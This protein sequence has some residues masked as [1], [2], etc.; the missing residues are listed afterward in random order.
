[1]TAPEEP[2]TVTELA[3]MWIQPRAGIKLNRVLWKLGFQ[4]SVAGIA[5]LP[6]DKGKPYCEPYYKGLKWYPSKILPALEEAAK[7]YGKDKL[8]E[9]FDLEYKDA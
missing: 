6:T 8:K 1:M 3:G 5:W 7:E 4:T 9:E 2:I